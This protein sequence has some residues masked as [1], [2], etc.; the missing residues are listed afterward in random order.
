MAQ[1]GAFLK[2][3]K[4]FGG[5]DD[6]TSP[7]V[8]YVPVTKADSDL[9]S[10]VCRTLLVGVAGTAKLMELDGTVR[11]NVP[12]QAGYNPLVVKQVMLGGTADN[13]WAVY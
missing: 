3:L 13:I 9:P 6:L 1:F 7:G 5:D 4:Q 11:N 12:L 8:K 10:G 2:K